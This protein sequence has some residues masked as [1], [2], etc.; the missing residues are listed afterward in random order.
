M[1]ICFHL[2]DTLSLLQG[3]YLYQVWS[4]YIVF[5]FVKPTI[6]YFTS[7]LSG[8]YNLSFACYILYS[9]TIQRDDNWQDKL[10]WRAFDLYTAQVNILILEFLR[11]RIFTSLA[12]IINIIIS[13]FPSLFLSWVMWRW[14]IIIY[15]C[16]RSSAFQFLPTGHFDRSVLAW[17]VCILIIFLLSHSTACHIP[18]LRMYGARSILLAHHQH[19]A[20]PP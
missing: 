5:D 4:T 3:S 2:F 16:L 9:R 8:S 15:T 14:I 17:W 11:F 10:G 7:P 20:I 1:E 12:I 6:I 18:Q 19:Q 13:E